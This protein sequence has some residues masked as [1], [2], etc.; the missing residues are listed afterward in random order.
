M[1]ATAYSGFDVTLGSVGP[2]RT[3]PIKQPMAAA[4]FLTFP[5]L[6][7]FFFSSEGPEEWEGVHKAETR[8]WQFLWRRAGH[9]H[10]Q[11]QKRPIL[12]VSLGWSE[13]VEAACCSFDLRSL[14]RPVTVF[15]LWA[16][17]SGSVW[18][19]ALF[20]YFPSAL[21]SDRN[22]THRIISSVHIKNLQMIH[23]KKWRLPKFHRLSDQ[24]KN[25]KLFS[26]DWTMKIKHS[27]K[28]TST[29]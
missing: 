5:L 26:S 11:Q 15:D 4:L 21:R 10:Q 9:L 27:D 13:S 29:R 20:F 6:T 24:H 22:N 28:E 16:A 18:H 14:W 2:P 8:P 23:Q 1:I 25:R 19:A 17:K 7:S 12:L 3:W